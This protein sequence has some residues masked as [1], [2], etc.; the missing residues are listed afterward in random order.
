[1]AK[2]VDKKQVTS[3][4]KQEEEEKVTKEKKEKKAAKPQ[5]DK[6]TRQ[7]EEKKSAGKGVGAG[8]KKV[9]AKKS[10]LLDE[11]G[12]EATKG[13]GGKAVKQEKKA[14]KTPDG[15]KSNTEALK[16]TEKTE[17][18]A[19]KKGVSKSKSD[20]DVSKKKIDS[21]KTPDSAPSSAKASDGKKALTGKP[22][23]MDEL[24]EAMGY[25]LK[26]PKKGEV[27]EGVVTD[28]T[29]KMVLVDIGGKTEGMVVDKEFEA[30]R[31]L[32]VDLEVGDK[33]SVY[34]SQPE[35][36]RGQILLSLKKAA[37]DRKWGQFSEYLE[38][39]DLID[40][41]GVEVNRGGLIVTTEG[42]RGFV[43]SSQFGKEYLGGMDKLL[44]KKFKVKV[45]EVDR[46]KNRL[47]F[48]E[49]L[50]SEAEAIA[51]KDKA[52]S[53]IKVGDVYEGVVSGIMPFGVFMTVTV[54]LDGNKKQETSNK[55][56]EEVTEDQV[57]Q[58]EGLVHISEIS[59]EKVND[60]NDYFKQGDRVR[61]KVLGVENG[62]LNL[63]VKQLSD[64]PW[65]SIVSKY[66]QGKTVK[67][68]VTR[69]APFGVFVTL[70]PGVDGLI[71]ISKIPAGSEP[72]VGDEIEVVVDTVDQGNRRMSLGIL[73]KEIPV[74]YR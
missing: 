63:S 1:M 50:V 11:V 47:I 61:V 54:P 5:N 71:H 72:K 44:N 3:D 67:G 2:K 21:K 69:T 60:P 20:R 46:E 7:K 55:K 66:P 65:S 4:K 24:L 17:K 42:I 62:K 13:Q 32:I 27:I 43:P 45:I 9:E 29:K 37:V 18:K 33:V 70:E 74:M 52:L 34:V 49:R 25:E 10:K 23:T 64:D 26:A 57:G 22:E 6:A 56:Q 48:S 59:W 36:D 15:K 68:K 38:T 28:V 12:G 19:S 53:V 8:E 41:T 40:V 16:K 30:T 39:G 73:L 58:V 31:D 35:N 51:K 14:E